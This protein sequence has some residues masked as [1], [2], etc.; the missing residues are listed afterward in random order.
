MSKSLIKHKCF[1]RRTV[2]AKKLHGLFA[3]WHALLRDA[4]PRLANSK[5]PDCPFWYG[6]RTQIG[7]L[8]LALHDI[9]W[10]PLQEPYV[11][12]KKKAA[13]RTDLWG[14]L[15]HKKRCLTFDFEAK[16]ANFNISSQHTQTSFLSVD[17]INQKLRRAVRQVRNKHKDHLGDVGVGLV[18]ALLYTR[19][20]TK[21]LQMKNELNS[22]KKLVTNIKS[23]AQSKLDFIALYV[24]YH[25]HVKRVQELY[26][27][28][29]CPGV[30]VFGRFA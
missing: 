3:K 22:F 15:G 19:R 26:G 18:F 17:D 8:A 12:R 11:M 9:G 1:Y 24:T 25:R 6:E 5:Y 30:V 4:T 20:G 28:E 21:K 7:W 10:L 16:F 23:M 2:R 27:Y 14:I 29:P 13:G